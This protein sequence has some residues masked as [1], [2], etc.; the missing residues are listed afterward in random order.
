MDINELNSVQNEQLKRL[1]DVFVLMDN[2]LT[3]YQERDN[4]SQKKCMKS[5]RRLTSQ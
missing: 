1:C 5:G 4:I 2:T 3:F